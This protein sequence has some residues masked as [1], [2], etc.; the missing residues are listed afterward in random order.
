MNCQCRVW[1]QK[2]VKKKLITCMK[3]MWRF[4]ETKRMAP[5]HFNASCIC[6]LLFPYNNA[7]QSPNETKTYVYYDHD[8]HIHALMYI[9]VTLLFYSIGIVIAIVSYINKERRDAEEERAYETY[10]AFKNESC[11]RKKFYRVQKAISHLK[12][13]DRSDSISSYSSIPLRDF[14]ESSVGIY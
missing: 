6:D 13:L 2:Y 5:I 10:F 7:T 8:N 14:E 3:M 4:Y 12:T 11:N 1:I 9:I